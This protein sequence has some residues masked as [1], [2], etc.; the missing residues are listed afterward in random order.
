[1][2]ASGA[3]R[4]GP[5]ADPRT[6]RGASSSATWELRLAWRVTALHPTQRLS[7]ALRESRTSSRQFWVKTTCQ[8]YRSQ[9]T[10][11]AVHAALSA[12][13]GLLSVLFTSAENSA[14]T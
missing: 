3:G 8:P 14:A 12:L 6:G 9:A 1:M 11:Q 10:L 5:I 4:P 13:V 2:P 7:P